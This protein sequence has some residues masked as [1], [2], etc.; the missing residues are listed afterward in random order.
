MRHVSQLSR[1][2]AALAVIDMQEPKRISKFTGGFLQ[3]TRS[4]IVVPRQIIIEVS[5]DG[6]QFTQ[7]YSGENYLPVDDLKVQ[8]KNIEASFN[9]VV[10]RYV[11]VKAIQYG[12]LPAWH[13]SA[14][15][16]THMFV[17]EIDL[18]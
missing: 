2:T 12:K 18:K 16:P 5:T 6:S 15:S 13:E 17:D 3:D 1:E 14:G 11:H 8:V 7:V 9:P 10:A 4:W